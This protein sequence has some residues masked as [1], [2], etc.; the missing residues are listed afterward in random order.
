MGHTLP[1]RLRRRRWT[2]SIRL[3]MG[4]VESTRTLDRAARIHTVDCIQCSKAQKDQVA[5]RDVRNVGRH[6]M[7]GRGAHAEPTWVE[8]ALIDLQE[9]GQPFQGAC[10]T[11]WPWTS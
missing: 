4:R 3:T 6:L 2:L 10:L 11:D 5:Q 7:S 1:S 9:T 8:L